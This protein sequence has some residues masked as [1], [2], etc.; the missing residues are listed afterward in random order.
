MPERAA[1][2]W[3]NPNEGR[4]PNG[5][6]EAWGG[7]RWP[8]G[9]PSHLLARCNNGV[10][11]R[12]ELVELWNNLFQYCEQIG[13]TVYTRRGGEN[14]GPWGYENR[15]VGGTNYASGHSI[16]VSV[17]INAPLNPHFT[18]FQCNMP[19]P[20]VNAFESCGMYW[21]GRYV[22]QRYDPM[23]F[24]YC[25]GPDSV[26]RHTERSRALLSGDNNWFGWFS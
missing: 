9:V 20:M 24:G 25:Y 26:A 12:K 18:T 5:D 23:H 3:T 21:G 22:G 2:G 7:Y 8:E 11:V 1:Y 10:I 15:Q 13:Y 16:G 17:D 14:W 6:F 4:P 19:V